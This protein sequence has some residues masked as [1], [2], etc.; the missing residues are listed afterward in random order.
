MNAIEK[1]RYIN[2]TYKRYLRSSF[3][4]GNEQL[5][6]MFDE[7]LEQETLYKGPYVGL[8]LPFK[9]GKSL[10]EMIDE[11]EVCGS[12]RQLEG[13]K[14]PF[15]RSLY[16]HQEQSIRLINNRR[17]IV[18]TTGTGSGKTESFLFPIINNILKDIEE[19]KDSGGVRAIFLYPMNALVND[20]IDR[21][22]ELLQ[23]CPDITFG[24]YTG[25]TQESGAE[26]LREQNKIDYEDG[27]V[28]YRIPDHELLT[29]E[30]IREN[31]PHLLFTNYSMLEY[32]LLRP[33]D[34]DILSS[35]NLRNWDYVVLD[36]AH[37]YSGAKG[38]EL[39][40]LMRRVTGLADNKPRF[41]LTSATL[42]EEGKSEKAIVDFAKK[43]T[44]ASFSESDIIFSKRIPL[45][46]AQLQ[47]AVEGEDYVELAK[48][49]NDDQTIHSICQKYI[50]VVDASSKEHLYELLIRDKNTYK[51]FDILKEESIPFNKILKQFEGVLDEKQLIALIDVINKAEKSGVNLFDLKYHSFIRPLM[52]AF[53]TLGEDSQLSLTKTNVINGK[54]AFELGNCKYCY[55]SYIFGKILHN[56]KDGRSYLFQN[57]EVDIYE[58]YGDVSFIDLDFF[59]FDINEDAQNDEKI[60]EYCLCQKCA[61]IYP[62]NQVSVRKCDCEEKFEITVYRVK[63]QSNNNNITYCPYCGRSSTSAL[64][65]GLNLG[66]DEGTAFIAQTLLEALDVPE[67]E[68]KPK[69]SGRITLRGTPKQTATKD[70]YV[71]QFLSFSDSR[72]QASFA[73]AFMDSNHTRMLRKRLIWQVIEN[74]NYADL[75]VDLLASE[76]TTIIKRKRLFDS[77]G[78]SASELSPH[79][80]AWITL[81]IDLLKVD[82]NY[83]GEG[84]GLYFF[85]LDLSI[86]DDLEED[87]VREVFGKYNLTKEDL[88]TLFQEIF[89]VFKT[90]PAIDSSKSTLTPD[91]KMEFLEYRRFDNSVALKLEQGKKTVKSFCPIAKENSTVRYVEKVCNCSSSEAKE[92]MSILWNQIAQDGEIIKES[93]SAAGSYVIDANKYVLKNYKSS[94]YYRCTKC[95]RLTPHNVHDVCVQDK[96]DGKLELANPDEVL[97]HNYYRQQYK[98]K[99][100]EPI[101]IEEH[102]AQINRKAAKQLQNDFKD[103]KINVLSCSTTFE[104][105]ID[106]GGLDTV[107]MR[108]IPP[109]PANYIQR[110]GR[111]GRRSDS[112]AFILTYCNSSSHDYYYYNEPEKMIS[113]TINPPYFDVVNDRIIHRHLMATCL[114]AFF[115]EQPLYYTELD[116]LTSEQ[117][118]E[119]VNGF[120]ISKPQY[121]KTYIDQKILPEEEYTDYHDF[122]WFEGH[123]EKLESFAKELRDLEEELVLARD[124]AESIRN[125]DD[126]KYYEK[127]INK[128]YEEDTV[129][130]LTRAAVI[131]KYGFPVDVVNLDVYDDNGRKEYNLDLSRDLKIAISEYAPDSEIIVQKKKYTSK[132]I[133]LPHGESLRRMYFCNCPACQKVNLFVSPDTGGK[134]RYCESPIKDH[135]NDYFLEPSLGFKTGK[136]K[137]STRMKPKRSY[138][139]EVSYLGKGKEEA[140]LWGL[141]NSIKLTTTSET[142][143]LVMNRSKFYM[144]PTCGF[145][146]IVKKSE[147]V[148]SCKTEAHKTHRRKDCSN[149][150]LDL[151]SVGHC[152]KTDVTRLEIPSLKAESQAGFVNAISFLYALLE[153][154]S[155]ALE[156][157]RDDIDGIIEL[158]ADRTSYDVVLYDDVPGGAGHV[159]RLA[160]E[161]A[162]KQSLELALKRVSQE[163]CDEDT[164]C[165]NCIRN[166]R[167]QMFHSRLRRRNAKKVLQNLINV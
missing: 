9:R 7:Q 39:S 154:V 121:L 136:T 54:K 5:Q 87:E 88:K 119:K 28:D 102:T 63:E 32:L 25:D 58:N 22:R 110:A 31:P 50:S 117:G 13:E 18:V 125:Y 103:K 107:Y 105:G 49:D 156:I 48:V 37:S 85:D 99:K 141:N 24:S 137:E 94:A 108:N 132:Y 116:L 70:G 160:K 164:S 72:Q 92:I 145:S 61:A 165:Y 36:E 130:A 138:A 91:E 142:E 104:M 3:H 44:S 135:L 47:Y 19:G 41:I 21:L 115:K 109:S 158:S 55:S 90:T 8:T 129:S 147:L 65:K 57:D 97:E 79:K 122:K 166:Y 14:L 161:D 12:F 82:G 123:D 71:K 95:G 113:G 128:L 151:L 33:K 157:D 146:N 162:L 81:L 27:K 149:K 150:K 89:G 66:K 20:Q 62:K 163:C 34:A 42:G 159:K 4:F 10:D 59:A 73:A 112:S 118:V 111:A 64:V 86:M 106:I 6:A 139:G 43:L 140:L 152:F 75:T 67:Q 78:A 17:S 29:R 167:N 84:L 101:R 134:C 69:T 153:G 60:E 131:P 40:M 144:C 80:N 126:A 30:E 100:I 46:S 74:N 15:D 45:S 51:L 11:G 93:D 52:G 148:S 26:N 53:V 2:S 114:S 127:Q 124:H 143:M 98:Q 76:L 133:S 23:T 68:N 16:F 38:I 77:T 1:A 120:I 83:D 155:L 35:D 96:C 56:Q